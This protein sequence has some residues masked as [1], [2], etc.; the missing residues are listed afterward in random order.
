MFKILSEK[1][2]LYFPY[3]NTWHQ[4]LRQLYVVADRMIT[5]PQKTDSMTVK[6]KHT[7]EH[8]CFL[9]L[10]LF[11]KNKNSTIHNRWLWKGLQESF[12]SLFL[13]A[14]WQLLEETQSSGTR[15]CSCSSRIQHVRAWLPVLPRT[16]FVVTYW[17]EQVLLVSH[18]VTIN[19][20][21]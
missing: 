7:N 19:S 8:L 16:L 14:V 6:V 4:Q 12:T 10:W 11:E 20:L 21:S 15:H 1:K 5:Q 3:S 18:G 13:A 9:F 17:S 2:T